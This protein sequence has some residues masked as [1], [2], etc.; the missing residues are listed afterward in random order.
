[1]A[2]R[3]KKP[4]IYFGSRSF[5]LQEMLLDDFEYIEIRDMLEPPVKGQPLFK[6]GGFNRFYQDALFLLDETTPW[7][8]QPVVLT[9]L[10]ANQLLC[11]KS[12]K[13]SA[14]CEEILDLKG[15]HRFDFDDPDSVAETIN[16]CFFG[17]QDGYRLQPSAFTI[18]PNFSGD[19]RQAGQVYH[20]LSGNFGDQ[21]HLAAYPNYA[22]WVPANIQDAIL[23]E[24]ERLNNNVHIK[25]VLNQYD[26][27]TNEFLRVDELVD[28]DLRSGFLVK[29][30][31]S[32]CNV[33]LLIYIGGSG[34]LRIGQFHLRRSRAPF[35]EFLLNDHRL[36]DTDGMNTDVSVYFDAGDLK[37][38]LSVYFS[39]YRSAEG[40]EG[41]YMM[42]NFGTPFLLFADSRLEGGA[43]YLGSSALQDQIVDVIQRTLKRLH[44]KPSDLLLSGLSMGT[45]GALYYGAKLAPNAIVVGKPLVNIGTIADGTQL[46]RESSEFATSLDMLTMYEGSLKRSKELNQRFWEVFKKGDFSHTTFVFAY[47]LN[48]DY[49][50]KAFQK[51]RSFLKENEPNARILS[52]GLPGRHNDDTNGIVI[53]FVMQYRHLLHQQY[54]RQFD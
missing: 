52:K 24:F 37:P 34:S 47:M 45:F 31:K 48:D 1:M 15:A 16:T 41:N 4:V 49:D 35:G 40:F 6:E 54:G 32:G 26:T 10:P 19:V 20:E 30:G 43:F 53:W 36:M 44:F 17:G 5:P 13:I 50:P 3:N 23:V 22:Q 46:R 28:D 11:E 39:G 18:A 38:P 27:N 33:Q 8:D 42:R 9:A 14:K 51:I 25:A 2:K 7:I 21:W 29:G 12:L